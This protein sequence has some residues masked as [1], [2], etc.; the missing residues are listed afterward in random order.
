M[1]GEGRSRRVLIVSLVLGLMA[2]LVV[3]PAAPVVADNHDTPEVEAL[4]DALGEA[5]RGLGGLDTAEPML[6]PVPLTPAGLDRIL[7]LP[8]TLDALAAMLTTA[9]GDIEG[10]AQELAD[11]IDV[12]EG[13]GTS[14][15]DDALD[16]ALEGLGIEELKLVAQDGF[17]PGDFDLD[18]GELA[19]TVSLVRTV[20]VPLVLLSDLVAYDADAIPVTATFS[21]ELSLSFDPD[22]E[23]LDVQVTLEE[24]SLA[25]ETGA[26]FTEGPEGDEEPPL[27]MN[28]G[29]LAVEATGQVAGAV[30]LSASAG[31]AISLDDWTTTPG[32]DLF[33]VDVADASAS[34]DLELSASLEGLQDVTGS[35]SLDWPPQGLDLDN[36]ALTGWQDA[37]ETE[38]NELEDFRNIFLEE[39]V[40]GIAQL[41]VSLGA[42]Q[43]S[44]VA[45]VRLPLLRERASEVAHLGQGVIEWLL[46]QEA[47]IGD[48]LVALAR[49]DDDGRIQLLEDLDRELLVELELTDLETILESLALEVLGD[50]DEFVPSYDPGNTE[51][52]FDLSWDREVSDLGLTADPDALR[53]SLSDRLAATTGLSSLVDAGDPTGPTGPASS[54]SMQPSVQAS[55]GLVIDL[56]H[57]EAREQLEELDFDLDAFK[58]ASGDPDDLIAMGERMQIVTEDGTSSVGLDLPVTGTLDLRGTIGFLGLSASTG[59]DA[60]R[61]EADG[62]GPMLAVTFLDGEQEGR[63]TLDELLNGLGGADRLVEVDLDIVVPTFDLMLKAEVGEAELSGTL[64]LGVTW[65]DRDELPEFDVDTDGLEDLL[66]FNFSTDPLELLE[67][68]LRGLD[69][70]TESLEE[71]VRA[72]T[73]L[74]QLPLVDVDIADLVVGLREVREQIGV[75]ATDPDATLQETGDR[76]NCLLVE[77][78]DLGSCG[79]GEV[80]TVLQLDVLTGDGPT[81]VVSRFDLGVCGVEG[82][83]LPSGCLKNRPVELPFQLQ[84][85]DLLDTEDGLGGILD[86]IVGMHAEGRVEVLY[87]LT[88]NLHTGVELPGVSITGSPDEVEDPEEADEQEVFDAV[89]SLDGSPRVVLFDSTR[90]HGD[91]T[92]AVDDQVLE[93]TAGPLTV[94]AGKEE[95]PAVAKLGM[96]FSLE[97]MS[98]DPNGLGEPIGLDELGDW[99]SGLTLSRTG[100]GNV[101]CPAGMDAI[102]H[103]AVIRG[104]VV[105]D[106]T[107]EPIEGADILVVVGPDGAPAEETDA[108]G[109]FSFGEVEA[110]EYRLFVTKDIEYEFH[111]VDDF[112]VGPGETAIVEVRLAAVDPDHDPDDGP[113]DDGESSVEIEPHDPTEALDEPDRDDEGTTDG[114]DACARL[115]LYV[116]DGWIGDITFIAPNLLD[117]K[118]WDATVPDDLADRLLAEALDWRLLFDGLRFVVERIAGA[119]DGAGHGLRV[120]VIGEVLDGGAELADD[121]DAALATL[122]DGLDDVPTH[123]DALEQELNDALDE[124]F[125]TLGDGDESLLVVQ[126]FC[127]GESECNNHEVEQVTSAEVTLELGEEET[128]TLEEFDLGFP[129]LALNVEDDL[130]ATVEWSI[131]LTVGLDRGG[132][133]LRTQED[134]ADEDDF[135]SQL[136]VTTTVDLPDELVG[137]LALLRVE[138]EKLDADAHSGE[139]GSGEEPIGNRSDDLDLTIDTSVRTGTDGRVALHQLVGQLDRSTFVLAVKGG[140]DLRYGLTTLATLPGQSDADQVFPTLLADL[141]LVWSMET[142][143]ADGFKLDEGLPGPTVFGFREIQVDMGDFLGGFLGPILDE[144]QRFTA[145]FQPVIDTISTPIPGLSD[146]SE[147]MGLGEITMIELFEAVADNDLTFIKRIIGL[148]DLA[149]SLETD[150]AGLEPIDL[151]S[152]DV[153]AVEAMGNSLS[154]SQRGALITNEALE[155][156][157][158]GGLLSSSDPDLPFGEAGAN[159]SVHRARKGGGFSFPAFE[160]P[161][162]LFGLLVGQDPVLARWSSGTL[163]AGFSTSYNFPPIFVGPVPIG[164]SLSAAAQIAGRFA[165]GFDTYGI[166]RAVERYNEAGAPANAR[167][168]LGGVSLLVNGVFLDDLDEDGNQVP[169]LILSS[170][171]AAGAGVSVGVISAG[172][173]L[174]LRALIEF[175]LR[176]P[177]GTGRIR[178]QHILEHIRTPICLFHVSG[179]LSVFLNAFVRISFGLGSKTSRFTIFDLIVLRMDDIVE[180]F[181]ADDDPDLAEVLD[182]GNG[183]SVL[184]LNTGARRDDRG[185]ARTVKDEEF[186]VRPLNDENTAF[187]VAAFGEYEEHEDVHGVEAFG[188]T[189]KIVADG[190]EGNDEFKLLDG[191]H[192]DRDG[193]PDDDGVL[194]DIDSDE[195]DIDPDVIRMTADAVICGGPGNDVILGGRGDDILVGDGECLV[196]DSDLSITIDLDEAPP[197]DKEDPKPHEDGNDRIHATAGDN[198]LF[199]LGG[200]DELY[201]GTGRD[202]IVGGSG[203]DQLSAGDPDGGGPGDLLIGGSFIQGPSGSGTLPNG[204]GHLDLPTAT[205]AEQ[206]G[207]DELFGGRGDDILIGDHGGADTHGKVW[208]ELGLPGGDDLLDGGPG[209][210]RLF[211]GPG[212]DELYGGRGDDYLDG[213]PGSNVLVGGSPSDEGRPGSNILIGGPGNDR[214]VAHDATIERDEEGEEIIDVIPIDGDATD[215]AVLIGGALL[216][217][218]DPGDDELWGSGGDDLLIGDNAAAPD[219]LEPTLSTNGQSQLALYPAG[220]GPDAFEAF[221]ARDQD[222]YPSGL[223][224]LDNHGG[225]DRLYGGPGDDTLIG[226]PGHDVLVGGWPVRT[227]ADGTSVARI[228]PGDDLL[229]GGRGNNLLVGDH[230]DVVPRNEVDA[231]GRDVE[232]TVLPGRGVTSNRLIGGRWSETPLGGHPG[233]DR[234]LA[235]R[236]GDVLVGDDGH[237]TADGDTAQDRN[238][239]VLLDVGGN[240]ELIGGAGDDRLFGGP[241]DDLLRG[242]GG[243]DYLEGGPGDD[244]LF[245]G[246]GRDILIGGSSR[247]GVPSGDNLLVG[248]PGD[249]ALAGDNARIERAPS[250]AGLHGSRYLVELFDVPV[251][252]GST[253]AETAGN[254]VL[255]GGSL[256]RGTASNDLLFGQGGED[257]MFGDRARQLPEDHAGAAD[258]YGADVVANERW[259]WFVPVETGPGGDDHLDG[260][261]GN[262]RLFGGPG[263]DVLIGGSSLR[264]VFTDAWLDGSSTDTHLVRPPLAPEDA[265]AE[266]SPEE[267]AGVP[268][269]NDLLVGGAGDDIMFGDN[270]TVTKQSS[271]LSI[272]GLHIPGADTSYVLVQL[273]VHYA[274]EV[275]QGGAPDASTGGDD[276]LIGGV[277]ARPGDSLPAAGDDTGFG[278]GGDDLLI[279]DHAQRLHDDDR[280]F[281]PLLLDA[282]GDPIAGGDDHLEGGPGDDVI[283]GGPGDDVLIGGSSDLA[284]HD[285]A[286]RGVVAG[287]DLIVGGPGRDVVL[288]DNGRV[289]DGIDPS[290][291]DPLPS[292]WSTELAGAAVEPFDE[293]LLG[294][295][296][297]SPHT[298]GD[299]LIIGGSLRGGAVGLED[300]TSQAGTEPGDDLLHGQGGDDAMFGDDVVVGITDW[301]GGSAADAWNTLPANST[302]TSI[303]PS[304]RSRALKRSATRSPRAVTT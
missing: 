134:N 77:E 126:L 293:H 21:A 12:A 225:D 250:G 301:T 101:T 252:D 78:L 249:D 59:P 273:D 195:V 206:S 85:S 119:L 269:G 109:R 154:A 117:D 151:G 31:G 141:L 155:Q 211:G 114:A 90:L 17:D 253:S 55:L 257:L 199:G 190:G 105:D 277:I 219:G 186:V 183:N 46:S 163:E 230:A 33:T 298:Y 104:T 57:D 251:A 88:A 138:L 272:A 28:V 107:D 220:L 274:D 152:F 207:D 111:T 96:D 108:D 41:A 212:D 166:R 68:L 160:Q 221:A 91:V 175:D 113:P 245:G 198:L 56:T 194:P 204:A 263:D 224:P 54:I 86:G 143:S 72:G 142:T 25:A 93:I 34:A 36:D 208:V 191:S 213:G 118:T 66:D 292:W 149:N 128:F 139:T 22:P 229:V 254:D 266:Q 275:G 296:P 8:E 100:A 6:D 262:D 82:D 150:Q 239:T 94:S 116:N 267:L 13:N 205:G 170:E 158:E 129:G 156:F 32:R 71:R 83:T 299:D 106:D 51:L 282:Q 276:E 200:D 167:D 281:A 232:A 238:V 98:G 201:G 265:L 174:G 222:G 48:E 132:F 165:I 87:G 18:A 258:R 302:S 37:V 231:V 173:E 216:D 63:L 76:L 130:D 294:Q 184:V 137:D 303:A 236:H 279:G 103:K 248:G 284:V 9:A 38:L 153:D 193:E 168:L 81:T 5:V 185:I 122:A 227:T 209:N 241:G 145:P 255:V 44:G 288:G 261:P 70:A 159:H 79:G 171:F 300:P 42:T 304:G 246:D 20:G 110:G 47:T 210:D 97:N 64:K 259:G 50:L 60:L 291:D 192:A 52:R 295:D 172:L 157:S 58:A 121:L 35:I 26:T 23:A 176:D 189:V 89:F 124:A 125:G 11:G 123:T 49:L 84:L 223:T 278:Q 264:S 148:V 140:A 178:I 1:R 115:P 102:P 62:D 65:D 237:V 218:T 256:H 144:V 161:S 40:A 197:D 244:Q 69:R 169:E 146:L 147:A 120:P 217:V 240:D 45:D 67:L 73:E 133:F 19:V 14:E 92:L 53:F 30:E 99:V 233:N 285:A 187:S 202:V 182:D 61:I 162:Q 228:E 164:F 136:E 247:P 234:L 4:K 43:H 131:E 75:I 289:H 290:G 181:C 74:G 127:G 196:D 203:D 95:N 180:E 242:G 24:V 179:Q 15:L 214:M 297:P 235:G 112:E 268:S 16:E 243:D 135:L 283:F 188:R 80:P 286:S 27:E 270:G 280:R 2:P 287:S 39:V 3:V 226:G 271:T 260:G 29:I 215:D 177:T 7:S 10:F